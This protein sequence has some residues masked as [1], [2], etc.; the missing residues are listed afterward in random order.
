MANTTLVSCSVRDIN[1]MSTVNDT[2]ARSAVRSSRN[3]API[4]SKRETNVSG[5]PSLRR[6]EYQGQPSLYSS[7]EGWVLLQ[8][9]NRTG[10]NGLAGELGKN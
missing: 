8:I 1:A 2:T 7:Q 10:I 4:S 5:L 3:Q 9:A 6:K